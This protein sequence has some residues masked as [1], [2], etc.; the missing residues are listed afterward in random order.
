MDR[1]EASHPARLLDNSCL[2]ERHSYQVTTLGSRVCRHEP[3]LER[4]SVAAPNS[5]TRD[6][7]EEALNRVHGN[8]SLGQYRIP[9]RVESLQTRS[10]AEFLKW[11]FG[12]GDL[13]FG[14]GK[15]WLIVARFE[16]RLPPQFPV[17]RCP[18][19][20]L[21]LFEPPMVMFQN[22]ADTFPT[23]NAAVLNETPAQ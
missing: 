19:D 9:V 6:K 14:T 13:G 1:D 2:R 21:F 7:H 15:M 20:R 8:S 11:G 4:Q 22:I 18:S 16:S 12:I 3:R 10:P 23:A 5:K 17:L